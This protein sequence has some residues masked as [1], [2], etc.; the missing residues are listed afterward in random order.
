MP[1]RSRVNQYRGVNAHLHSVMQERP[2]NWG[3]FHSRVINDLFD[4]VT[5]TLPTGYLADNERSLQIREFNPDSGERIQFRR[6]DTAIFSPEPRTQASLETG[7]S[8]SARATFVLPAQATFDDDPDLYYQ[9]LVIRPIRDDDLGEVIAW[10]ELLSPGN[11]PGG[12]GAVQYIEKRRSLLMAGVVLI[13]VDWLHESRSPISALPSYPDRDDHAHAYSITLTVPRPSLA[14]GYTWVF[15]THVD[16][17]LPRI[18]VPL[19]E[20]DTCTIDFETSYQRHFQRAPL[21]NRLVNYAELPPNVDR[22]TAE[23]QARIRARMEAV[24]RAVASGKDLE[25]GPFEIG[26]AQPKDNPD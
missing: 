22:Y 19:L 11:K 14:E 18:Q 12:R 8:L 26:E 15:G 17:T 1:I 9:S 23:D 21:H 3:G 25:Q 7:A 5:R 10:L 2:R 13:E 16:Q 4:E 24:A 20:G 6:P